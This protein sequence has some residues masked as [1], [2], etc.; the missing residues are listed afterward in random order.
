MLKKIIYLIN[1]QHD[2]SALLELSIL[3]HAVVD[4]RVVGFWLIAMLTGS[5]HVGLRAVEFLR[6]LSDLTL[7]D[8]ARNS[9]SHERYS[10][11]EIRRFASRRRE[12]FVAVY[13]MPG[14]F[15]AVLVLVSGGQT[16]ESM[17]T[18]GWCGI[19]LIE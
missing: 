5:R 17:S 15:P 12:A 7:A 19:L 3:K 9:K 2:V 16:I 8:V 18:L 13:K 4:P 11:E 10:D 14:L 1:D 6:T